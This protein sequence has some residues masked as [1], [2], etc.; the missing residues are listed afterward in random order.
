VQALT[1]LEPNR[2]LGRHAVVPLVI[3][4]QVGAPTLLCCSGAA[5]P[6][7]GA[8]G[9]QLYRRNATAFGKVQVLNAHGLVLHGDFRNFLR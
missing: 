3:A 7:A 4:E 9:V 8:A 6:H 2:D 1:I 5:L